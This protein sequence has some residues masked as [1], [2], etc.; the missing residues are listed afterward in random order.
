[1]CGRPATCE[2]EEEEE[3]EGE[4]LGGWMDN[5]RRTL[6]TVGGPEINF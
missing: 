2:E 6:V 3:G 1:M 4:G 5:L